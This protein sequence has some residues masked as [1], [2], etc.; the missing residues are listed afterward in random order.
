MHGPDVAC[1][2]NML[3]NLKID[4]TEASLSMVSLTFGCSVFQEK[5]SATLI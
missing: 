1:P 5:G 3:E 2:L 4:Q